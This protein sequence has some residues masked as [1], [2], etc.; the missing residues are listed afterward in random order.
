MPEN[1]LALVDR[2]VAI[3]PDCFNRPSPKPLKIGI[4][5][6]LLPLA[7]N[8][9]QL[10]GVS[11]KQI[12]QALA[13][14][15]GSNAYRKAVAAGGPRYGLNGQPDGE[16]TP[17]QQE[18]AKT[19]RKKKAS[20]TAMTEP[21]TVVMA[22]MTDLLQEVIAM[23]IPAKMD[24]TI[25]I[26]ELPNCKPCSPQTVLFAV[27]AHNRTVAIELR[28]K[29]WNNLKEAAQRYPQWVA[30]ITGQPGAALPDGGFRL[31]NPAVQVFEKKPKPE[32]AA[33][34]APPIQQPAKVAAKSEP[35]AKSQPATKSEPVAKAE[36]AA[37]SAAEPAVPSASPVDS[38]LP[39]V[40]RRPK[41]SLKNKGS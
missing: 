18:F 27:Q 38:A 25:K 6:E 29:T 2:L 13:F 26:N 37:S 3:F 28:N 4:G 33:S 9:P 8:H 1:I 32:A 15:T 34:D 31:D 14:Y 20:A 22:D 17:E 10:E 24:I 30:A 23:A 16:V 5:A 19:P 11:R 36:P 21:A 35:V 7:G 12:R 40:I 39:P 41:L